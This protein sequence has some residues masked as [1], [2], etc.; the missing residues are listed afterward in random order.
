[1]NMSDPTLNAI[2]MAGFWAKPRASGASHRIF[3]PAYR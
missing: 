1:M 3:L 2:V